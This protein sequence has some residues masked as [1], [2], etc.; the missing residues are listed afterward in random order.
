MSRRF[1][2]LKRFIAICGVALMLLE[3]S[4]QAHAL[5]QLTGCRPK[6][7]SKQQDDCCQHSDRSVC[8]RH[9][10]QSNQGPALLA[11]RSCCQHAS[12]GPS[13]PSPEN[14]A[15]CQV[16]PVALHVSVTVVPPDLQLCYAPQQLDDSTASLCP[17]PSVWMASRLIA[18]D[19]HSLATCSRLCRFLV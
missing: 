2:N 6:C 8:Q 1:Q 13:C 3:S 11:V 17:G 14:C 9:D 7:E 19:S 16:S 10:R 15:C 12:H 18:V 4:Q 5:C